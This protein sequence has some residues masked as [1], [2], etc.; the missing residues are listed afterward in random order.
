MRGRFPDEVAGLVL[1]EPEHEDYDSYMPQKLNELYQAWGPDEALPEEL[2][3]EIVRFYRDLFAREMADWPQEI[4]EPL[5]E[6]HVSPGMAEDGG[7]E[8]DNRYLVFLPRS[9][10]PSIAAPAALD[11]ADFACWGASSGAEAAASCGRLVACICTS[12][13]GRPGLPRSL[14]HSEFAAVISS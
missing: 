10:S 4:R 12:C 8:A 13:D 6:G 7:Q 5:I 11:V 1:V 3:D 2:P 14:R 9:G